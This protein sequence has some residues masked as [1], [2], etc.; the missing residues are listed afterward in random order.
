[1][2][3]NCMIDSTLIGGHLDIP[4]AV[5]LCNQLRRIL[6]VISVVS[7]FLLKCDKHMIET[8]T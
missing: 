8:K 6:C 4:T 1:M 3:L 2:L 5:Q 7:T